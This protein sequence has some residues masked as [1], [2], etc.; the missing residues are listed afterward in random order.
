MSLFFD[1]EKIVED[2]F[3]K[4][5]NYRNHV[6]KTSLGKHTLVAT[7]ADGLIKEEFA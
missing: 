6:P 1:E 3:G 4:V 7:T 2:N 5:F